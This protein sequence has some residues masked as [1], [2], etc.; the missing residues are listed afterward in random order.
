VGFEVT[1]DAP[2]ISAGQTYV[3]VLRNTKTLEVGTGCGAV[4]EIRGDDTF[5]TLTDLQTAFSIEF[6]AH[7]VDR[8]GFMVDDAF[9]FVK[10]AGV[11]TWAKAQYFEGLKKSRLS[12]DAILDDPRVPERLRLV[13]LAEVFDCGE[14]H[15]PADTG[16]DS[17]VAF[18]NGF[19]QFTFKLVMLAA[20]T[21][22]ASSGVV[23]R[24]M[25][26]DVSECTKKISDATGSV[27]RTTK[28]ELCYGNFVSV[29]RDF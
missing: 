25:L 17:V 20:K 1:G 3:V 10:A 24:S 5:V 12:A 28:Q 29:T 6:E 21:P 2:L 4:S 15:F 9:G 7:E 18:N 13:L 11:N 19:D 22:S 8:S 16:R 27:T 26:F 23:G 14:F